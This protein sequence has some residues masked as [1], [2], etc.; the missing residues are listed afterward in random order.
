MQIVWYYGNSARG[1]A[2]YFKK[3]VEE[4]DGIAT[5]QSLVFENFTN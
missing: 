3:Q 2:T 4:S 1:K 5:T